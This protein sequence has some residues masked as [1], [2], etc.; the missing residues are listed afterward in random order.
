M[1]KT[2]IVQAVFVFAFLASSLGGVQIARAQQ[3]PSVYIRPDGSVEPSTASISHV[4]DIYRI[5]NNLYNTLIVE[6]NNIIIDGGGFTIQGPGIEVR[7]LAGVNLTCTNV[8]VAN[9]CIS[10]WQVGV[11]GVFD[12]NTIVANNFTNNVLDVAVYAND[13]KIT[14]NNIGPE[15]IVGNNNIISKN[16]IKLGNYVS[17]FWITSSSGTLIEANNV[18]LSKLTTFFISTDNGNFR[19]YHNNFLNV[20]ENTGGYLLLIFSF[21]QNHTNATSPPWDNGYLSGGNYWSDYTGRNPQATEIG[22]TGIGNTPY[23]SSTTPTVVD[24]YP[25]LKP[26][27]ISFVPEIT[28]PR[29]SLLSPRNQA[30]NESSAPLVF[31]VNTPVNW[32]GY[33][34]NG[35]DNVTIAGN[36]TLTNLVNGSHNV[37]MYATDEAGNVVASETI[38][39]TVNVPE[40]SQQ[41]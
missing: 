20:E 21:P 31:T 2:T 8:T 37:T 40:L 34:L 6:R 4:R 9:V 38:H 22:N 30:Y 25:L 13:Y 41:R 12:N 7:D 19:V 24:R 17:G 39:F 26:F 1:R 33:S 14:G 35:K 3:F 18:T 15:R 11:L 10:G 16:Q 27:G 5:T 23:V 28:A 32:T 29:I 36:I